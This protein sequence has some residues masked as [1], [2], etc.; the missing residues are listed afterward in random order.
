MATTASNRETPIITAA[1]ISQGPDPAAAEIVGWDSTPT[2]ASGATEVSLFLA[3]I[4][5]AGQ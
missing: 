4:S 1:S 5:I 2:I 3:T